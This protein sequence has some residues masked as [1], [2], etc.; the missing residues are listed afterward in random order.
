MGCS[1]Y[2]L[3]KTITVDNGSEFLDYES[4][5]K[6]LYRVGKRTTVYYCHPYRSCE[7]GSNENQNKLIRRWYPK[8]SDFDKILKK[9]DVKRVEKW[10]NDYPRKMFDGKTANEMFD[11]EC[12]KSGISMKYSMC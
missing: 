1:F 2:K 3:F 9:R 8:G 4:I 12:S 6:A 5:E 10:I 11:D 7:R